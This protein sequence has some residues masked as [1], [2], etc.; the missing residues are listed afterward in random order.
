MVRS[1]WGSAPIEVV[2]AVDVIGTEAASVDDLQKGTGRE[3]VRLASISK[4]R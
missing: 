3:R 2:R 4:Y 1:V